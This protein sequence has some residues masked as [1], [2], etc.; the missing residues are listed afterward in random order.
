MRREFQ[1]HRGFDALLNC[2]S[3][4]GYLRPEF[5]LEYAAGDAKCLTLGLVLRGHLMI[6]KDDF[7]ESEL[8]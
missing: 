5:V 7:G 1:G 3:Q 8:R 4:C 2:T 6:A